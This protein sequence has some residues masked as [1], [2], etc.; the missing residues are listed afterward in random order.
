VQSDV[1]TNEVVSLSPVHGEVYSIQH[2]VIKFVSSMVFSRYSTNKTDHY[3][4]TDISLK[5]A[6]NAINLNLTFNI[7]DFWDRRIFIFFA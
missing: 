7:S 3:D 4:I 6:L 2:Y 5:V 1:I